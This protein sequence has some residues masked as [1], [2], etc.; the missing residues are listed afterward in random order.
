MLIY[1]QLV[2][3]LRLTMAS[4][5][6][7]SELQKP[8]SKSRLAMI[9]MSDN[10]KIPIQ[11][12]HTNGTNKKYWNNNKEKKKQEITK[13]YLYISKLLWEQCMASLFNPLKLF[14]VD[15]ASMYR[16]TYTR[17]ST[18]KFCSQKRLSS[19]EWHDRPVLYILTCLK[20]LLFA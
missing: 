9:N 14:Y 4:L 18:K 20:S 19:F 3:V 17:D 8:I 13:R 1:L 10:G 15:K 16:S 6:G 12:N 5:N 11:Q 2:E 7:P